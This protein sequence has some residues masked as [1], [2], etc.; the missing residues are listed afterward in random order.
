VRGKVEGLASDDEA[1]GVEERRKSSDRSRALF[2]LAGRFAWRS[3]DPVVIACAGLSGTGKSAVA[4]LL[5]EA[6]GFRVASSDV[7]RKAEGTPDYGADARHAVYERLR[8][9]VE[10]ALGAR[11]SVIVDATFL[12]RA[13]RDALARVAG[14]Y[15]HRHVFVACRADEAAVKRRLDARDATSVSDARWETYLAQRAYAEPFG[16]DEPVLRI[17]TTGPLADVRA[18]VLPPLWAWR[19]GRPIA[20]R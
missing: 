6:T 4:A 2:A 12:E 14:G 16:A 17:D 10:E 5:H 8:R 3:G 11:E 20:P 19:N 13:E 18:T 15:G 1:L 7:V 9:D